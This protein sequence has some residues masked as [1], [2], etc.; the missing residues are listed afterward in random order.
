LA[1]AALATPTPAGCPA[2]V[3]PAVSPHIRARDP[4]LR[5]DTMAAVTVVTAVAVTT[6]IQL[7]DERRLST[8]D[9]L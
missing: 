4:A 9:H 6:E 2:R 5:E 8:G 3:D 7:T 1:A